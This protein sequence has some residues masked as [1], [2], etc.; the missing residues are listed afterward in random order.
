MRPYPYSG[1]PHDL[2]RTIQSVQLTA[3]TICKEQSSL[4]CQ[5]APRMGKARGKRLGRGD[6][7]ATRMAS[8]TLPAGISAQLAQD[9]ELADR[10]SRFGRARR[11]AVLVAPAAVAPVTLAV[12]QPVLHGTPPRAPRLVNKDAL[13]GDQ[14]PQYVL[15]PGG[16][17]KK[18]GRCARGELCV[19]ASHQNGEEF[20]EHECRR[21]QQTCS[22]GKSMCSDLTPLL[23]AD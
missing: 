9:A 3:G 2:K 17:G 8:G 10:L 5:Q 4:Y 13:A 21:T 19:I 7:V 1:Q 14:T 11:C 6:A 22:T 16:K 18:F 23:P 12:P 20:S 15:T